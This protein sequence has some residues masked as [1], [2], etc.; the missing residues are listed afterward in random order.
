MPKLTLMWP[1]AF[2]GS[3]GNLGCIYGVERAGDRDRSAPSTTLK[4]RTHWNSKRLRPQLPCCLEFRA[5]SSLPWGLCCLTLVRKGSESAA[6]WVW[7]K[8]GPPRAEDHR[9]HLP[10]C[11]SAMSPH[12]RAPNTLFVNSPFLQWLFKTL[13]RELLKLFSSRPLVL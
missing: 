1:P 7:K 10:T 5:L 8:V 12:W 3:F 13:E 2:W 4:A 9:C 11:G 6:C